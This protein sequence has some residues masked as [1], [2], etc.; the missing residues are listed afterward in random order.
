MGDVQGGKKNQCLNCLLASKQQRNKSVL[1]SISTVILHN[2]EFTDGPEQFGPVTAVI[3]G[4]LKLLTSPKVSLRIY[5][6]KGNHFEIIVSLSHHSHYWF[7]VSTYGNKPFV[8]SKRAAVEKANFGDLIKW[9]R[10]N[11]KQLGRYG[12]T[13]PAPLRRSNREEKSQQQRLIVAAC[14]RHN[15]FLEKLLKLVNYWT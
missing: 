7:C 5:D 12:I 6:S 4:S 14:S 2:R 15:W 10:A 13:S 1:L 9:Q 8:G 11:L 3:L